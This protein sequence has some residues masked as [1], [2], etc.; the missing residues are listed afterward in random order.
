MRRSKVKVPLIQVDPNPRP[1]LARPK[2][3]VDEP[4]CEAAGDAK[5]YTALYTKLAPNKKRKNKQ[6]SDGVLRVTPGASC[7]LLDEVLS[8]SV[9]PDEPWLCSTSAESQ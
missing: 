8:C 3:A 5:A 6:F 7:E 1:A 9:C 4:S 2:Q